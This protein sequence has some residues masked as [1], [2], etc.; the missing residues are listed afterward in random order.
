M[1]ASYSLLHHFLTVQDLPFHRTLA[2]KEL[3][4]LCTQESP[5]LIS[6]LNAE[7]MTKI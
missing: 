6:A 4:V 2:S 5:Q 3:L 1:Q 7:Q